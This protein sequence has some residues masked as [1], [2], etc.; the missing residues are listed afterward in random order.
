MELVLLGGIAAL[1]GDTALDL[2]PARQRCVLAALA[3]DAG[4]VVSVDRLMQRVWGDE[5]PL[6]ARATLLNYLSRLRLLLDG[7]VVRR[8]GGYTLE[9]ER[10]DIDLLRFRE[11]CVRAR[12]ADDRQAEALLRQALDLWQG[13]ALTGVESEWAA[14]ERNRLHQQLLD[15]ECDL[16]EVQLRLGHGEDLVAALTARSG[17]WPLDER[18]AAHFMLALHRAGRTAD[19][20]AHFRQLRER[21]VDELGTDPGA[22]LQEVHQRILDNDPAHTRSSPETPAPRQLPGRPRWFT[23]RGTELAR[24]DEA[25]ADGSTVVI[26]AIGGAGGIGK[27]WL[28]LHWAHQHAG[29]FPDGQLFID[30]R[31]FNPTEQPVAPETALFGFLTALGVAPNRVPPDLDAR[32]A[33]YRSLIADR[34]LLVVLDNAA[35]ADQVAP[36]LPGGPGCTVLVTGRSVLASLIDRHGARHL[37][38]DALARTEARALLAARLGT[39][40]VAAESDA[41]DELIDLCG[42]YPLALAITAR[43]AADHT[44]AEV[45]AELRDLGL[46]M[47]DH[48]TDPGASLSAVLSWSLRRLTG[49]HRTVFGLLGITPGPDT[50]LPAVAALTGLP[51]A[52]ARKAL[53][54]LEEASLVERRDDRYAMH[55]LI[56]A[57]AATTAH[58]L[59]DDVRQAALVRVMDFYLHTAQTADRLLDPHRRLLPP[60]PPADSVRPHPLPDAAAALDWLQAEHATLLATQRAALVLGRHHVV[61]YLAWALDNFHQR[62]GHRLDALAAWQAALDAAAHLPDPAT[63]SRAHRNLGNAWSQLNLHE[64]ATRHLNQALAQAVR[65]HDLVEQAH[66][67]RA[68]AAAWGRRGDDQRAMDHARHA[69]DLH[70]TLDQPVLEAEALNAV[71]W[72]AARTGDADTARDHCHAALALHRQHHNPAG[73]ANTLDSLGFI[74]HLTGDHHQAVNHYHQALTLRRALGYAYR[75]ADTLDS[76]GRPHLALGQHER[77][78]EV[79]EEALEL[80]REQ[81]RDE[82]AA[83]VRRRLDALPPTRT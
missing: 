55:D 15:A 82:D 81:G 59:P 58:D 6:R 40:R 45:A 61:W 76:M 63:R 1:A 26:S 64:E 78:R 68:L 44:L 3:V 8:P 79:W 66:T 53:S 28:A 50:T 49:E 74:E 20:L 52:R 43:H 47:L 36:L 65:H 60:D 34:R 30:L 2:G 69:L 83:R 46:E 29:R 32:S 18:V 21:L 14:A 9:V 35:T 39:R 72:F 12:A 33:L 5:P 70:R 16:T 42:G 25:L 10:S 73:E 41:V 48:S 62:R 57:Y 38:L 56:R 22:A 71:G 77:A 51:S 17:Q 13:E 23:G 11:L 37:R 24:L 67:H 80:Y 4:R 54:A 27:T 7:A 75:V 31:G 19:A